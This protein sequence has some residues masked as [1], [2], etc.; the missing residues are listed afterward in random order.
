VKQLPSRMG[1]RSLSRRWELLAYPAAALAAAAVSLVPGKTVAYD[2]PSCTN[3][4]WIQKVRDPTEIKWCLPPGIRDDCSVLFVNY[5]YG[6]W[7]TERLCEDEQDLCY[8]C[9]SV[10]ESDCCIWLVTEDPC[11]DEWHLE[12]PEEA[13]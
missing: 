12:C 2:D 1:G 4:D 5:E 8:E 10:F 13:C 7:A 6:R 9:S 11:C 3:C